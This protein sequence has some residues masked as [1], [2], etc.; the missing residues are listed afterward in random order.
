MDC[1][2]FFFCFCSLVM[3]AIMSSN[4]WQPTCHQENFLEGKT[5]GGR[6]VLQALKDC[7]SSDARCQV[8]QDSAGF[9]RQSCLGKMLGSPAIPGLGLS[10]QGRGHYRLLPLGLGACRRRAPSG[11]AAAWSSLELLF[12]T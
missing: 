4:P 12:G 3:H 7:Q 10:V 8:L 2:A 1:V 6:A 11:E 5:S 9:G